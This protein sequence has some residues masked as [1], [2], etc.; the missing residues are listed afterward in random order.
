MDLRGGYLI[1]YMT[2]DLFFSMI[3]GIHEY[4]R[5]RFVGQ[6]Y[7]NLKLSICI[8]IIVFE[9]APSKPFLF[10]ISN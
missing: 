3:S 4:Q 6:V 1:L 8:S 5:N 10:L 2:V 9:K 7:I